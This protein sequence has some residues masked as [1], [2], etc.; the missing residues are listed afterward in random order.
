MKAIIIYYSK[1]GATEKIAKQI[2]K[3]IGCEIVKIDTEVPYGN[4]FSAISRF[5]KE[6][7]KGIIPKY[8]SPAID[9]SRYDT[10]FIGYP[11][12]FNTAP[13]F[14]TDYLSKLDLTGKTIIP[15]STA[16][17]SPISKSIE[18]LK[19]VTPNAV[20]KS[21]YGH[22]TFGKNDGFSNWINGVRQI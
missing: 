21:P 14:L 18:S 16:G 20:I 3:E 8:K 6:R 17:R 2:Q 11:I 19:K 5:L 10:V 22:V 15:F 7:R 1:S 13:P 4:Y 12:W 9:F